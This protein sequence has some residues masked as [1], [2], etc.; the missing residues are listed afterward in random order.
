M[1][2]PIDTTT[3]KTWKDN[4]QPESPTPVLT[5]H[6]LVTLDELESFILDIKKKNADSVRISLVRFDWKENEPQTRKESGP[7][8]PFGCQWQ[9]T[10][11]KTQVA[12]VMNGATNYKR[13]PDYTLQANDIIENDQLW[14]L[15][16][17]GEAEGPTGHNPKPPPR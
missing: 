16:P 11:K 9:V 3:L 17:G 6:A 14:M 1:N 10:G 5:T 15:I 2:K 8:F 7:N 4:L 13:N 12:I